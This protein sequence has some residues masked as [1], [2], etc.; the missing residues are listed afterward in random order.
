MFRNVYKT[1][2]E[3]DVL[4]CKYRYI[5]FLNNI[6]GNRRSV[7]SVRVVYLSLPLTKEMVWFKSYSNLSE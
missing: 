6:F 3:L 1:V 5:T 4:I 7:N 2:I